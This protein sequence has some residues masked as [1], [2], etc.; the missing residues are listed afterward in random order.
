MRGMM[1]NCYSEN[2]QTKIRSCSL[3]DFQGVQTLNEETLIKFNLGT[4][5]AGAMR[6]PERWYPGENQEGLTKAM[7]IGFKRKGV[8][9]VESK[10]L[11]TD[12][13]LKCTGNMGRGFRQVEEG[14]LNSSHVWQLVDFYY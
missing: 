13:Y 1:C 6:R 4:A 12:G 5:G 14:I 7:A 2:T 3:S 9:E 8:F 10:R 11:V